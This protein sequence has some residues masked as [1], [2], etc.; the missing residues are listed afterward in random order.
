M[1]TGAMCYVCVV[2]RAHFL[3]IV[4]NAAIYGQQFL[5]AFAA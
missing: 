3:I 4:L 2:S 1:Q 5:D